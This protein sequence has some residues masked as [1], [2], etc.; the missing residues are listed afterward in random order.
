MK[1][2]KAI[3]RTERVEHVVAGLREAGV[4]RLAISHV[5]ALGSGVDPEHFRLSLEAD[6]AYTEK[7][8]IELICS[9]RDVERLLDLVRNRACT[10][11]RGDGIIA[12]LDVERCVRIRTGDQDQLA[13]M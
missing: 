7:A 6:A 3:I 5:Q 4:P 9:T 2:L 1:L 12:V 11:H 10:G 8:K 13:L